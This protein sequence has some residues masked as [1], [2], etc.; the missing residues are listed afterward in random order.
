MLV[1]DV[2]DHRQLRAEVRH[3]QQMETRGQVA[4]RIAHDFNNLLT[5]MS[6]YAEILIRNLAE[7]SGH[8]RW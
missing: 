7:T 8:C 1:D 4:S 5:L 2:T 3:A 6:G